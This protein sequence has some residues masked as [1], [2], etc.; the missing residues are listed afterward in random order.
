MVKSPISRAQIEVSIIVPIWNDAENIEPFIESIVAQLCLK[1]EKFEIIF[2][3]DP[4]KDGTEQLI[5][6]IAEN[7]PKVKAIF[8]ASRSGQPASTLAGLRHASGSAIIV[9]D[10]DLQDP[11]ELIPIMIDEWRAGHPLVI[12]RRTSRSGEPFTKK[13]TAALGYAFLS[14]FGTAPIPKNTGDF[15]LMDSSIVKRVLSLKESHVFLR[16][17]VALVDQNPK[18]IDFVRPPRKNG[19]SK[20]NKWFG[21]IKS[22]LNGIVSF[23]TALLDWLIVIGFLMALVSFF[24]GAKFV[25]YK[26]TGNYIPPGNT[27]LFAMVTFIGGMQ[28]IGIGVLGLYVG[29]I[30]EEVKSR[31]RWFISKTIGIEFPDLNDSSRAGR[32][33]F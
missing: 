24:V 9:L 14:K 20:Y 6:R 1:T 3:I 17:L 18:Y 31:P 4:S 32:E 11:V 30:F 25:L 19:S 8:F 27:Q 29:R 23:S 16:G 21:G 26:L 22:G 12:P 2:C 28:L 13:L 15:R 10:V 33:A 5:S 7:N